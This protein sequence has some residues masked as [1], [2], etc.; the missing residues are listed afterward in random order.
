MI[1]YLTREKEQHDCDFI[2]SELSHPV[3]VQIGEFR[4]AE[5]NRTLSSY[6]NLDYLVINIMVISEEAEAL[7]QASLDITRYHKAQLIFYYPEPIAGGLS[8]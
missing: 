6:A 7:F 4:L 3:N 2:Q 5:Y 1:I 8:E